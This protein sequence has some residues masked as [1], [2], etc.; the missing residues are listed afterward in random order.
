MRAERW[1]SSSGLLE[2]LP[3]YQLRLIIWGVM[4]RNWNSIP[5]QRRYSVN[6]LFR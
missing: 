3:I 2:L 4:V 5:R 6:T 1:S